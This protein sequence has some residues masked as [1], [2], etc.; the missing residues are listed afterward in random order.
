MPNV[1][2]TKKLQSSPNAGAVWTFRA[3][4]NPAQVPDKPMKSIKYMDKEI[5]NLKKDLVRSR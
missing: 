1:P 2:A 5:V 3:P 4:E